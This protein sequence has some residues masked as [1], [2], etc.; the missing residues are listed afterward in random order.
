MILIC[1]E[2]GKKYQTKGTLKKNKVRFQCRSCSHVITISKADVLSDEAIALDFQ[3]VLLTEPQEEIRTRTDIQAESDN[4]MNQETAGLEPDKVV[5]STASAAPTV[6]APSQRGMGLRVKMMLL[7]LVVPIALFTAAGM[8]YLVQMKQFSDTLTDEST[9]VVKKMGENNIR[10]IARLVASQCKQYLIGH[11]ELSK[12]QFMDDPELVKIATQRVGLT[13]YAALYSGG[14]FTTWVHVSRKIIGKPLAPILRGPLGNEF[15]RFLEIIKDIEQ[16]DNVEN[17][18]YY[19]WK[20]QDGVFREKFMAI[21][22]L[23]G[24]QFGIAATVYLDEFIRPIKKIVKKANKS[25]QATRNIILMT[26]GITLLLMASIVF[27]YA[28]RITGR[29]QNLTDLAERISVGEMDAEINI[30]TTDEIGTLGE[31]ISRMQDSIRLSIER[32]RRRT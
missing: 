20:D 29:I 18:G 8:Y 6:D 9:E 15:D 7:F 28:H 10:E 12:E 25:T 17:S 30:E 14:P 24:T 21:T 3:S 31:A 16:G 26:L 19:L 4:P 23:E 22:P 11:P 32:L 27:F 13:G 2:C 5:P 1:E